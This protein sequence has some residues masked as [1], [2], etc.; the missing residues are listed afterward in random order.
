MAVTKSGLVESVDFDG[1]TFELTQKPLGAWVVP[2]FGLALISAVCGPAGFVV[3]MGVILMMFTMSWY[4]PKVRLEV[5]TTRLRAAGWLGVLP[6]PSGA[7]MPVLGTH[8]T[9]KAGAIVNDVQVWVLTLHG[10]DHAVVIPALQ[11]TEAELAA[12]VDGIAG[13]QEL[14]RLEAGNWTGEVPGELEALRGRE[15]E[16]VRGRESE[17]V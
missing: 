11:C 6:V 9:Y 15:S 4:R 14:A 7:E 12:V 5:G 1:V 2:A 17:K 8:A 3:F 16:K 10:P 13:M